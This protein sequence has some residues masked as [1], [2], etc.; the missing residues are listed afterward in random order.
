MIV[1][2]DQNKFF[3]VKKAKHFVVGEFFYANEVETVGVFNFFD[4][5]IDTN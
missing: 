3:M 2:V 1:Q 5:S 4:Q